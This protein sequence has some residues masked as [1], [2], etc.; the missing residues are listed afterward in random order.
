MLGDARPPLIWWVREVRGQFRDDSELHGAMLFPSERGGLIGGDTFAAALG[1]AAARHLRGPVTRLTRHVLRPACASRL[2][3]EGIGLAAIQQLL[4]HRWL[5]TTVRQSTSP[6][7][8]SRAGGRPGRRPVQGDL[9][10]NGTCGWLGGQARSAGLII[11]HIADL[12]VRGDDRRRS[13]GGV[14]RRRRRG[15]SAGQLT[16]DQPAVAACV[17]PYCLAELLVNESAYSRGTPPRSAG[18]SPVQS[19]NAHSDGREAG[20]PPGHGRGPGA[21]CASTGGRLERR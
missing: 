7:R 16:M 1:L 11:P 14:G 9:T 17:P 4:R 3:G 2:Y 6:T 5:S 13:S 15:S 19:G 12:A 10:C 21:Q 20:R 8:P 18:D